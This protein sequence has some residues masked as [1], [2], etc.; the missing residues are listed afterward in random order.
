[1]NIEDR[2]F[3]RIQDFVYKNYGILLTEKKKTLVESR[4]SHILEVRGFKNFSSYFDIIEADKTGKE[5]SEFINKITTNHTYFFR[6]EKHFNF[7]KEIALPEIVLK[8]QQTRDIRIWSAG[9]SSGEEAYSIVMTLEAYLGKNKTLWDSKVLATDISLKVLE[10]ANRGE[11]ESPQ[12]EKLDKKIRE[13][14]FL[15][16]NDEKFLVK[17]NIKNEV[18]FRKFNLMNAFPFKKKFHIIFCRNVMIY[19]DKESKKE[20]INKFYN[21]LMPGGYLFI[22]HSETIEDRSQGFKYIQPAIYKKE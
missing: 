10:S 20:L 6:E 5:I 19:F 15:K 9:C 3:R 2:E 18:I 22:G 4:F 17:S 13:R 14:Y 11:Y 7:L 21:A 8:E 16:L 1:M 12:V